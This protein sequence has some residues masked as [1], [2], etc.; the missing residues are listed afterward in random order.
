MVLVVD[1]LTKTR[2][3]KRH[4]RSFS[5][6]CRKIKPLRIKALLQGSAALAVFLLSIEHN[7]LS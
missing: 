5:R 2:L 1:F 4:A 6:Q 3:M 7:A